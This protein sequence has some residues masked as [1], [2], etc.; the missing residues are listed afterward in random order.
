FWFIHNQ[1]KII[2]SYF[3]TVIV[4]C[5]FLPALPYSRSTIDTSIT[6]ILHKLT[7]HLQPNIF[8]FNN[9]TSTT[10]TMHM[11]YNSSSTSLMPV[12]T[13][14]AGVL[15]RLSMAKNGYYLLCGFTTGIITALDLRMGQVIDIWRGYHDAV[16]DVSVYFV[17]H[18]VSIEEICGEIEFCFVLGSICVI[19]QR[20]ET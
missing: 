7:E 3:L 6:K 17:T 13:N 20:K 15:N 19:N 14:M 16:V 10:T 12:N 8:H 4:F 18:I 5:C 11:N 2:L 9:S 1:L